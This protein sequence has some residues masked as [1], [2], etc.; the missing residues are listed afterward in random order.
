[1][2]IF[3]PKKF[4]P[5]KPIK[6]YD[7]QD[8]IISLFSTHIK[9]HN[10]NLN[11]LKEM[12][13]IPSHWQLNKPVLNKPQSLQFSFKLGLIVVINYGQ[14]SFIN[15]I[16]NN[17][18]NLSE[19][20]NKFVKIFYKY[21]WQKIQIHLRRLISLPGD[22]NNGAKFINE[23]LL[24]TEKWDILG[25][26]PIKSQVKFM[27]S[28]PDSPLII[29]IT[30]VQIQDNSKTIKSALLFKGIFHYNLISKSNNKI[31]YI[32]SIINHYRDNIITFNGIIEENFK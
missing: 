31:Q 13:I 16:S 14:I 22:K 8:V 26:K 20:I 2:K 21:N 24:Q 12:G 1:M 23:T 30:D 10:F 3:L 17:S 32:Y 15:K 27:Y 18:I 19:I 28:F 9:P 6:I 29:T 11:Q 25:V 5:Q 4:E 7:H